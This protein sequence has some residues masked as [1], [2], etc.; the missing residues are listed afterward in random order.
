MDSRHKSRLFLIE[1]GKPKH[2]KAALYYTHYTSLHY[3]TL[4]YTTLHYT[5]PNYC[6]EFCYISFKNMD[7]RHKSRLFL[8]EIGKPK[9]CK[10][11]LYYTHYTTLHYTTLHYTTLHYTNTIHYNRLYNTTL[12]YTTLLYTTLHYSHYTT[13]HYTTLH[14]T[15][16]HYVTTLNG[17]PIHIRNSKSSHLNLFNVFLFT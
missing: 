4:H 14:Y 9:H 7:S 17:L 2:C 6:T 8:I 12:H 3:T 16:L 10:A 15:T 1:F 5:T 13:L 11:A